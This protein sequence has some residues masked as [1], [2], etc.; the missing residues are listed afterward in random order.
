[1]I[2]SDAGMFGELD[3][4]D[5]SRFSAGDA[6]MLADRL[7][8]LIADGVA[9]ERL[10]QAAST[11]ADRLGGWDDA[12]RATEQVYEAAQARFRARSVAV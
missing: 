3:D 10:G 6:D 1:M 2:T 12:A 4:D 5:V 7:R 9:R 8:T 11:L